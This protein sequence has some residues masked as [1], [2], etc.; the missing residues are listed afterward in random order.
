MAPILGCTLR[1]VEIK[2]RWIG[3]KGEI[4]Q[5]NI[6]FSI[7]F[8]HRENIKYSKHGIYMHFSLA[9]MWSQPKKNGFPLTLRLWTIS[10]Y[11][12]L[13][14]FLYCCCILFSRFSSYK[15]L[16]MK[17]SHGKLIWITQ[18]NLG[19]QDQDNSGDKE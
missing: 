9:C 11:Y 16:V 4:L 19:T 14:L 2:N 10:S 7:L 13:L 17:T 8:K 6:I 18:V 1:W 3:L 12:P 15:I 5:R